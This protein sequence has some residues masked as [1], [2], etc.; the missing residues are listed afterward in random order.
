[1]GAPV[2][3]RPVVLPDHPAL[4]DLVGNKLR[5]L[6]FGYMMVCVDEIFHGIEA[7]DHVKQAREGI[8]DI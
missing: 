6:L 5:D 8:F 4:V 2:E 7:I 1:M 3:R